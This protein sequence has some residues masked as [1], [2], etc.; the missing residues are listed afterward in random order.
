M[1]RR[2]TTTIACAS[3]ALL[4]AGTVS[5]A[6]ITWGPAVDLTLSGTEV[7][8]SGTLVQALNFGRGT[9]NRLWKKSASHPR[10]GR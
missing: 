7:S 6:T 8:T 9:P 4:V 10:R 2:Y 1:R 5:A 3:L